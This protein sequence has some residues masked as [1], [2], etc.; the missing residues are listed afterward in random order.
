MDVSATLP[1]QT[2]S[3][4]QLTVS[5]RE[6]IQLAIQAGEK[7][8]EVYHSTIHIDYK[9]DSSPLTQADLKSNAHICSFLKQN[10]PDVTLISEEWL[11]DDYSVR[12]QANYTWLIDPLDGTKEFIHRRDEFTVNIGLCEKGVPVMGVVSVPAYGMTYFAAKGQGAFKLDHQ[13][14]EVTPLN[15]SSYSLKDPDL[16]LV[17]SLSHPSAET[18]A[19]VKQFQNPTCASFGSS[20]KLLKVAEGEADIYPRFAPTME[21]DTCA[22]HAIL[23]EAGGNCFDAYTHQEVQYNKENLRNPFFICY[24]NIVG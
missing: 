12:S 5:M 18:T 17:V 1:I 10:Y 2:V 3:F 7:V 22:A 9:E 11:A 21:W 14:Q 4:D 23:K 15:V 8:M 19:F 16:K 13:T 20:L 24:G 6:L